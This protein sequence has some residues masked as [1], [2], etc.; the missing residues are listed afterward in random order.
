[1]TKRLAKSAAQRQKRSGIPH[2]VYFS[3]E[4]TAALNA[5]S[6]ARRV[7]KSTIIR[8]AIEQLLRKLENG[9]VELPLG[10]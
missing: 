5:V 1:M 3:A 9:Q 6:Q 8:I 7:G 4:L 10:L 2:T